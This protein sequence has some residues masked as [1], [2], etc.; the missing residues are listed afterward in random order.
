MTPGGCGLYETANDLIEAERDMVHDRVA[1]HD[2]LD[3]VPGIDARL[4]R[5]LSTYQFSLIL[6]HCPEI[7]CPIAK[8]MKNKKFLLQRRGKIC[9]MLCSKLFSN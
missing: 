7:I 1:D 2:H 6:L 8:K 4:C 3:D 9:I 5:R